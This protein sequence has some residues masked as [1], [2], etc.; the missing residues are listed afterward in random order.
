MPSQV[1]QWFPGHMAKT[2]RMI[3]ENLSE[4]DAVLELLDSRIPESSKNPEIA[5]LTQ[6]KPVLTLLTKSALSDPAVND[7]WR[8]K[9]ASEGKK[10]LFLDSVTGQGLDK[11]APMVRELCAEKV[12]RYE[13]KGMQGRALRVMVVGIPN[14]GKSSLINRLYGSKKARVED[15]PGVTVNK[16]WVKCRNG[17]EL[18]DM[19]GVLWPKFEDQRVGENLAMTGAIKDA[20]MDTETLAVKLV[21]RLRE[22]YPAL[23]SERYKL[24][25]I[26]SY[27]NLED[28]ELFEVIGKKRGFLISGGEINYERTAAV[29]LDEFRGAKI[30]R[31]SL[32]APNA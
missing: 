21:G 29:L 30:G 26:E 10:C 31:I 19:P 20:V 5:R 18:L 32:E 2:R 1:I 27:S 23:L 4:V 8:A 15:R 24:D 9:Y 7:K 12:A 13:E 25:N 22:S 28:W 11:I 17:L 3:T 6:G 16:Q 14:V